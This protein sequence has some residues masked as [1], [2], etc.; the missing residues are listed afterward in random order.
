VSNIEVVVLGGRGGAA[1]A[2]EVT[3]IHLE[4]DAQNLVYELQS[5]DFDL[6]A[7]E[8][9][10]RDFCVFMKIHF[11]TVLISHVPRTWNKLAHDIA[12]LETSRQASRELWQEALP[13]ELPVF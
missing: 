11:S 7:E 10:Y 13:T 3:R 8:E 2:W 12:S 6:A 4:S 5:I 1:A 9:I